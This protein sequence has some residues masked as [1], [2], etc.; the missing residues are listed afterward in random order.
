MNPSADTVRPVIQQMMFIYFLLIKQTVIFN[1]PNRNRIISTSWL[2]T[3]LCVHLKPINV[4][5]SYDPS[6]MSNLE[7]GFPL[8]CFQRLSIPNIATERSTRRQ[9]SYTRGQFTSVLSYQKRLFSNIHACSRQETNLSHASTFYIPKNWKPLLLEGSDCNI[10]FYKKANIQSLRVP[11]F[12]NRNRLV[13]IAIPSVLSFA[14]LRI[15]DPFA[16]CW[17]FTEISQLYTQYF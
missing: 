8:R 11:D 13:K 3:L 2:N 12:F 15:F 14:S 1:F 16:I 5:I 6:A 17:D 9:S 10:F 4:I 7:A